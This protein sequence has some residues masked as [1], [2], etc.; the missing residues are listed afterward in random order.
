MAAEKTVPRHDSLCHYCVTYKLVRDR[1]GCI[2]MSR[3]GRPAGWT[4]V[5]YKTAILAEKPSCHGTPRMREDT[6]DRSGGCQRATINC[7]L[8]CTLN[9]DWTSDRYRETSQRFL[10][11]DASPRLCARVDLSVPSIGPRREAQGPCTA[12]G[13]IAL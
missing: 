9:I 2:R 13:E 7:P 8:T 4:H 5:D 1:V 10:S 11:F 12:D 6:S 3:A